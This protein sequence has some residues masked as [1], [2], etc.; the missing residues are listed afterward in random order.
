MNTLFIVCLLPDTLRINNLWEKEASS[1]WERL[2]FYGY[3]A[4]M[5]LTNVFATTATWCVFSCQVQTSDT[6]SENYL[7]RHVFTAVGQ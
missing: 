1:V 2:Y 4:R 6:Y 5:W 3:A 7:T